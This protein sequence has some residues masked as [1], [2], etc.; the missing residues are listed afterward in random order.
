VAVAGSY[1]SAVASFA[2]VPGSLRRSRARL[3]APLEG[4]RDRVTAVRVRP[5]VDR[6]LADIASS[7]GEA[8]GGPGEMA[9]WTIHRAWRSTGSGFVA[10]VGPPGRP[11]LAIRTATDA[12]RLAA[13]VREHDALAAVASVELPAAF[14]RLLPRPVAAG[15][16]DDGG[17][18]AQQALPGEVLDPRR[19]SSAERAAFV[20]S[21]ADAI[22]PLHEAATVVRRATPEDLD[23][24]VDARVALVW[25]LVGSGPRDGPAEAR[26][27]GVASTLRDSLRGREVHPTR[28]H[29]DL[30]TGNVLVD[31]AASG[32]VVSGIVDW[33]SSADPELAF[34]DLLH[35]VLYTRK[36][37]TRSSLGGVVADALAAEAMGPIR[38]VERSAA[39]AALTDLGTLT[40]R[41]ALLLYWLRQ[42]ELNMARNPDVASTPR[43]RQRNIDPVLA[44]L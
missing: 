23:L 3:R 13:L 31:T 29:G 30:W 20:E 32:I 7:R 39:A 25:S 14:S 16:I 10:L 11:A 26:L 40:H 19:Q 15:R 41:E 28:I 4:L 9:G 12:R 2:S 8:G 21:I 38:A 5:V 6:V 27:A 22:R 1:R 44:C 35:L 42:V 33:D 43:W 36:L 17:Y 24:W 34:H 18:L 37:V